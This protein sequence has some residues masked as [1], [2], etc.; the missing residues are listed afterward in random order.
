MSILLSNEYKN[1]AAGAGRK[2]RGR[3]IIGERRE[4]VC[5]RVEGTHGMVGPWLL[6]VVDL[7]AAVWG[8]PVRLDWADSQV[9]INFNIS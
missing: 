9:N 6:C 1:W 2:E 7:E 8:Y 5:V 3:D 4:V